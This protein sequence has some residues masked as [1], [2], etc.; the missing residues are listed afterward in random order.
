MIRPSPLWSVC[1]GLPSLPLAWEQ[2][3]TEDQGEV[4]ISTSQH[5]NISTSPS[6]AWTSLCSTTPSKAEEPH[7][8]T[9]WPSLCQLR[10]LQPGR[11]GSDRDL[12]ILDGGNTDGQW[13]SHI[14][15]SIVKTEE[16]D[17]SHTDVHICIITILFVLFT[18]RRLLE[19]SAWL[20]TV[21]LST[22]CLLR[23]WRTPSITCW[24]SSLALTTCSWSSV[25]WTTALLE[26]SNG[27]KL[28]FVQDVPHYSAAGRSPRL[29]SFTPWFSP[30]FSTLWTTS[31]SGHITIQ[32]CHN[33]HKLL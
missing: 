31:L 12:Q 4:N 10:Q 7:K 23:I 15:L 32:P 9:Y 24:S 2:Q 19:H 21:F 28:H 3:L 18:F 22:S 20:G 17:M 11:G 14:P 26:C 27:I 30:S 6:P 8:A 13:T 25:W 29:G 5:L 16:H 1:W 33:I